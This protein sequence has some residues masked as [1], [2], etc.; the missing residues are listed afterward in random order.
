MPRIDARRLTCAAGIFA[1]VVLLSLL[2]AFVQVKNRGLAW[3]EQ[4]YL[5]A[6]A[7][8]TPATGS[9]LADWL[10]ACVYRAFAVSGV[11]RPLG[12]ALAAVRIAE[13][14]LIGLLALAFWRRLGVSVRGGLLG[15]AAL[16]W[17][18]TQCHDPA[19]LAI[20]AY[21]ELVFYLATALAV[22]ARRDGLTVLLML[23]AS[24]NRTAIVLVPFMVVA[25]QYAPELPRRNEWRGVVLAIISILLFGVIS[26]LVI[27]AG[28]VLGLNV[29]PG[30]VLT[31]SDF[32][33]S[34]RSPSAWFALIGVAGVVPLLALSYWRQWP[35]LLRRW[36]LVLI[37][38]WAAVWFFMHAPW[39]PVDLL[40]PLLL[41][42]I[43]GTLLGLEREERAG[44][45]PL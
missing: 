9:L 15:L 6:P 24:L 8:G 1:A 20:A 26:G 36:F 7:A 32:F 25:A 29:F 17:G 11:P 41:F 34:V 33:T 13:N 2:A 14:V 31:L 37:P 18:M 39:S 28:A 10:T 27:V 21:L 3:H 22:C 42:F 30:D 5:A 4:A 45:I 35:T 19:G 23:P 38:G 16:T 12:A 44:V 40:L 43:P